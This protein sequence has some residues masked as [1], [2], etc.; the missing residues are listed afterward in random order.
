MRN[1]PIYSRTTFKSN[2]LTF[3]VMAVTV[4]FLMLWS[5]RPWF[6][7]GVNTVVVSVVAAFCL[8]FCIGD[9]LKK[10]FFEHYCLVII[11]FVLSTYWNIENGFGRLQIPF[12]IAL[13][14]NN[15]E[16]K[17]L[18]IWWTNFYATILVISLIAWLLTWTGLLPNYGTISS[19]AQNHI[20]TNYIFCLKGFIY[21]Y[22]FH[23][24]FLEP[25]HVAMIAVFTLYANKFNFR[26]PAVLALLICTLFTLSLAGYVLLLMGFIFCRIQKTKFS[27]ILIKNTLVVLFI[28]GGIILGGKSYNGGRNLLNEL[29]FERL[30]FDEDKG[31]SGNNRFSRQTDILF[32]RAFKTGEIVSGMSSEKYKRLH[33][34]DDIHGAGYKLYML[35]RGIIGTV[36]IFLFYFFLYRASVDKKFVLGMLILYILA[37]LQRSY[38]FWYS[39]LFLFLFTTSVSPTIKEG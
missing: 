7:W 12:I 5:L 36:L 34:L 33:D 20:Y 4:I 10:A 22:R 21:V 30:E 27:W 11:F 28:L 9:R 6:L 24:V 17:R 19:T 1:Y 37:F 13:A 29:I 35:E 15:S 8:F 38:P 14:M 25:G 2:P 23:S 16:K 18:L 32:E 31:F 26:K 39:W 3:S